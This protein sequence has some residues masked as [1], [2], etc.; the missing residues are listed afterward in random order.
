MRDLRIISGLE[1]DWEKIGKARAGIRKQI[2]EGKGK[3]KG[4]Y[5]LK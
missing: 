2:Q 4:G 1:A 3:V 5:L